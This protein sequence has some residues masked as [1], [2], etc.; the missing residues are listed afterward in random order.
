MKIC[1]ACG[2]HHQQAD[3]SCPICGWTPSR[4]QGFI[5]FAP[6]ITYSEVGFKPEFFKQLEAAKESHFWFRSR[7]RLLAWALQTYFPHARSLLE[8]SCGTGF[9]LLGLQAAFPSSEILFDA[10]D[11]SSDFGCPKLC[12]F[13]RKSI[14]VIS[15]SLTFDR[16]LSLKAIS[17]R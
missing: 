17:A 13:C 15:S 11:N 14:A 3:W 5:C 4:R 2:Q 7:N 12:A 9:V 16:S 10:F 6:N 1:L 8:V